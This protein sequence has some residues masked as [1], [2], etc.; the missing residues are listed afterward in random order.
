MRMSTQKLFLALRATIIHDECAK[1]NAAQPF[2]EGWYILHR[3]ER[4]LNGEPAALI[5]SR[6]V[7]ESAALTDSMKPD[8]KGSGM[9][10]WKCG[11]V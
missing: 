3:A 9:S 11:R 5:E 1:G 10:K 4:Y 7:C 8:T 2:S 6:K